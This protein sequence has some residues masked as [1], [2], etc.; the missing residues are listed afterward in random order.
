MNINPDKNH[1]ILVIDDNRAI[2]EDFR[3]VLVVPNTRYDNLAEA[4]DA[5]F[6]D[7][8]A[9][10]PSPSPR[11]KPEFQIDSAFQGEEGLDLIEK[12]LKENHPY[13]MAFVDVRMPPGS[14]G[15]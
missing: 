9:P 13:A 14:H 7:T 5:L 11:E 4:E 15:V 2:H 12:S 10:A 8:P 1:R 6:A 3:K